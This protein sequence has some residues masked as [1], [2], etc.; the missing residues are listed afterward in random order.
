MYS[1]GQVEHWLDQN[2]AAWRGRVVFVRGTPTTSHWETSPM[3]EQ[4]NLYVCS[5]PQPC[6]LSVPT[7]QFAEI[8][9]VDTGLYR[10][11]I[12]TP[13]PL[14]LRVP[15]VSSNAL[16]PFLRRL[17]AI[18]SLLPPPPP[19]RRWTRGGV[20]HIYRIQ[21]LGTN[22]GIC[23]PHSMLCDEAVLLDAQP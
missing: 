16:L 11:H 15:P 5:P 12:A 2:P 14:L 22:H 3:D 1:V 9:L 23:L 19:P 20:P 17:P 4:V 10:P 21:L 6:A 7:G 13:H 8:Y 18:G